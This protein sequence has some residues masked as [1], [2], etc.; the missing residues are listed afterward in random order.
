MPALKTSTHRLP[1]YLYQILQ[2]GGKWIA[3]ISL[4]GWR[5]ICALIA[6]I[7]CCLRVVIQCLFVIAFCF[8]VA[9][10]ADVWGKIPHV[11]DFVKWMREHEL[12]SMLSMWGTLLSIAVAGISL[13]YRWRLRVSL[14]LAVL[15]LTFWLC[16]Y[17]EQEHKV[18]WIHAGIIL[19]FVSGMVVCWY[20]LFRKTIPDEAKDGKGL[21]EV[22]YGRDK[23]Y[24]AGVERILRMVYHEVAVSGKTIAIYGPWGSGKSHFL[25][26]L[27]SYISAGNVP[28]GEDGSIRVTLQKIDLWHS[29]DVDEAWKRIIETLRDAI[30]THKRSLWELLWD[31]LW[32]ILSRAEIS[33]WGLSGALDSLVNQRSEEFMMKAVASLKHAINYPNSAAILVLDDVERADIGI[34][35]NLLP[36]LERLK[37]IPGLV[38]VCAIARDE[39]EAVFKESGRNPHLIQ[40]YF[41]KLFDRTIQLP[42]IPNLL[43]AI[44]FK[45][46]IAKHY[47]ECSLLVNFAGDYVL[48]FDTP[49]QMMRVVD[50]L[51]CI[52]KDYL[53]RLDASEYSAPCVFV[54]EILRLVYSSELETLFAQMA[55]PSQKTKERRNAAA[56]ET[57]ENLVMLRNALLIVRND[58]LSSGRLLNS[59]LYLIEKLADDKQLGKLIQAYHMS[60]TKSLNLSD[61]VYHFIADVAAHNALYMPFSDYIVVNCGM[62]TMAQNRDD[63][64]NK[65][66]YFIL[67]KA[68]NSAAYARLLL[69]AVEAEC[70]MTGKMLPLMRD[71]AFL[72]DVV[73][74][75]LQKKNDSRNSAFMKILVSLVRVIS[76]S[77][78]SDFVRAGYE[79]EKGTRD[80]LRGKEKSLSMQDLKNATMNG[81]NPLRAIYT[82]YIMRMIDVLIEHQDKPSSQKLNIE[83]FRLFEDDPNLVSQIIS[84][85]K[86]AH[87]SNRIVNLFTTYV[88]ML[89]V[90]GAELYPATG[91]VMEAMFQTPGAIEQW[92]KLTVKNARKISEFCKHANKEIRKN[93]DSV[94]S[95]PVC[96][97]LK[98]IQ[99]YLPS[100]HRRPAIYIVSNNKNNNIGK[101]QKRNHI[102]NKS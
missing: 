4:G 70:A 32:E 75:M 52:E 83:K 12:F 86:K 26:Y 77:K 55:L 43:S 3:A 71:N 91:I 20:H 61:D 67:N 96:A 82:M 53:S 10:T 44:E 2:T 89:L 93:H 79:V 46:Y 17:R 29:R 98:A 85:Y 8:L 34:I 66:V 49:R 25:N 13:H 76:I 9:Y 58:S 21:P 101:H 31:K 37:R 99:S 94:N 68:H 57:E 48:A 47:S 81:L 28:P 80:A 24:Q 51:A 90:E 42:S 15:C 64:A 88:E 100:N 11:G 54:V 41:D 1:D 14:P 45:H 78:L 6:F 72:T 60:Y 97:V 50:R 36:L 59:L 19:F 92:R 39:M 23:A 40:G 56:T 84:G 33:V 63:A 16:L 38:V 69:G 5:I 95:E 35:N 73:I 7:A 65:L 62:E 30:C 74:C 102:G 87:K 18:G 27:S 22:R